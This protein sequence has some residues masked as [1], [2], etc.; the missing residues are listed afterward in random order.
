MRYVFYCE[1]C[2][3]VKEY[4]R[5]I[6]KGPPKFAMCPNC[7]IK[8]I[9]DWDCQFVLRGSWPG[10]DIKGMTEEREKRITNMLKQD[11]EIVSGK[12]EAEEV[13]SH[14]RKG[15]EHW[16]EWSRHNKGKVERY[17]KNLKKGI[18]AKGK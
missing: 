16:K 10:K 12:K 5:S 8:M 4:N 6:K 3:E 17:K 1:D 11:D 13:L 18:R 2:G 7:K 15:T 9:R 14:R